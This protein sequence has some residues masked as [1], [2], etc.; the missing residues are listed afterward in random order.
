VPPPPAPAPKAHT[1]D[2]ATLGEFVRAHTAQM[3]FCYQ[4]ALV[5]TPN[6]AG[7]VAL[8]VTITSEGDVTDV[9][10]TRR[11]WTGKPNENFE[12]CIR[13]KVRSWKFPPTDAPV[14]TFPLSLSFTR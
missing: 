4:E 2:L 5:S 1:R 12:S 13:A 11:S 7:A 3:N 14:G 10:V 9:R 8:A 6:L